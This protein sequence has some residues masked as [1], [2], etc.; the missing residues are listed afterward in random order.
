MGVI[1]LFCFIALTV[2]A[3]IALL[4][5]DRKGNSHQGTRKFFLPPPLMGTTNPRKSGFWYTTNWYAG[6]KVEEAILEGKERNA[7]QRRS[8]SA[9]SRQ[10]RS[11]HG[12]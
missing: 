7:H 9:H 12:R 11:R 1:I 3:L 2:T 6:E 5:K 10:K 4:T 8:H